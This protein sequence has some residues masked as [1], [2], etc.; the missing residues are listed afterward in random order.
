MQRF[1]LALTVGTTIAGG[2]A[3]AAVGGGDRSR[4]IEMQAHDPIRYAGDML[5]WV[6]QAIASEKEFLCT[7]FRGG[8]DEIEG[9]NDEDTD[10][11]EIT[12][13][14]EGRNAETVEGGHANDS[15][16]VSEGEGGAEVQRERQDEEELLKT[17]T[18]LLEHCIQGLARP[19]R[20]RIEG[21]LDSQL[22]RDPLILPSSSANSAA[23]GAGVDAAV[24][25]GYNLLVAFRLHHL[26]AFYRL[27]LHKVYE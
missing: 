5:A 20:V 26:L 27:T 18:E 24:A 13:K 17:P 11:N 12:K 14:N 3:T 6:H 10:D 8:D 22:L 7:L 16:Q 25:A 4:P 23:A 9:E 21:I 15:T 19:L 2:G 1:I